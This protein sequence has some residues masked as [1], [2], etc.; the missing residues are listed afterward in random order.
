MS[1]KLSLPPVLASLGSL[2]GVTEHQVV[3]A[4][5]C[6]QPQHL[7]GEGQLAAQEIPAN[8]ALQDLDLGTFL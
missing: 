5:H 1:P 2:P 3:E 7:A 8:T 6:E 4:Q